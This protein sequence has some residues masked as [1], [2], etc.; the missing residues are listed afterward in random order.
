VDGAL[1]IGRGQMDPASQQLFIG[2]ATRRQFLTNQALSLLPPV[3]RAPFASTVGTQNYQHFQV[4][5]NQV[6]AN[7][8]GGPV[9][10][11]A[12]DWDA[13]SGALIGALVKNETTNAAQAASIS[14][15]ASNGLFTEAIVAG[16]IGLLAVLVSVFMVIWFGRKIT[17]DL[18]R[19]HTSVRGM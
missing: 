5:E 12:K 17:G 9:P 2:T 7:A 14:N 13:T 10:V 16:G 4:L 1:T 6:S 11:A 19:L 3:L 8:G 18:G 15:A